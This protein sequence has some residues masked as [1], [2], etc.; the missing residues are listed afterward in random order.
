MTLPLSGIVYQLSFQSKSI[1]LTRILIIL[2]D[3]I[4]ENLPSTHLGTFLEIL[5]QN[6]L[7]CNSNT[8]LTVAGCLILAAINIVIAERL[9]ARHIIVTLFSLSVYIQYSSIQS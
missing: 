9:S 5:F 2:C 7:C 6:N 4:W 8:L 3:W 1:L